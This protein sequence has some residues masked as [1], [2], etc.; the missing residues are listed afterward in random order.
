M[1]ATRGRP[2]KAPTEK[3]ETLSRDV[4]PAHDSL[5]MRD[6]AAKGSL[7]SGDGPPSAYCPAV[8]SRSGSNAGLACASREEHH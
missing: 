4:V 1:R 3:I 8:T 2:T 7:L 6:L 5:N